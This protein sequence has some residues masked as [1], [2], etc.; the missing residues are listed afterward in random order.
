M[1]DLTG[2]SVSEEKIFESVDESVDDGRTTD[3][4][5]APVHGHPI[6]SLLEPSAQV[7]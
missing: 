7:S 6:S 1:F 5:R 4:W 3:E 2:Q